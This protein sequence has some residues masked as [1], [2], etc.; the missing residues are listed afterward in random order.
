M[1]GSQNRFLKPHPTNE[2]VH[3]LSVIYPAASAEQHVEGAEA[4]MQRSNRQPRKED[5]NK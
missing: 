2:N 4:L 5:G 1:N 3:T